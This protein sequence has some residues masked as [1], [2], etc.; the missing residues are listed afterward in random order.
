MP[1]P[2]F[3]YLDARRP[4]RI[5][6]CAEH[7]GVDVP[8]DLG[9]MGIETSELYRHIGW[10]LGI[11]PLARRLHEQTGYPAFLGRYSRLVADLNRPADSPECVIEC[12]DG[13]PIPANTGLSG[14]QHQARIDTYH[15]PFHQAFSGLLARLE[16]DCILS[17]HSF[18]PMLRAEGIPRPWHC[19]I[20]YGS[21]NG[22]A[23]RC[24]AYL[25]GIPGL[26]VG[27]N[28]PYRVESDHD[29]TIPVH[30]D[31]HRIPTVIVEIRNDLIG[32]DRGQRYWT[33]ILCGMMTCCC[34]G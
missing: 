16:P 27:D 29:Y 32:N 34:T 5:L 2:I 1:D 21:A 22:L 33:D 9:G 17:L 11:D 15:Q 14:A 8:S 24:L 30:G 7:A 26:V 4:A 23:G 28:Q 20:L 6:L 25:N 19:G 13:T 31:S 10:D 18:T 3:H 12:S